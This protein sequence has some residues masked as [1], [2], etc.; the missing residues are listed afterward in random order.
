MDIHPDCKKRLVNLLAEI[1]PEIQVRNN[2]FLNYQSTSRLEE[3]DDV[4]PNRGD[5]KEELLTYIGENPLSVF[6]RE[7][8]FEK[9]KDRFDFENGKSDKLTDLDGFKNEKELSKELITEFE[10]LPWD[11]TFFIK[12]PR[13]L[14]SKLINIINEI[15]FSLNDRMSLIKPSNE[16]YPNP[17]KHGSLK[18]FPSLDF[19]DK[20]EQ[21]W[22]SEDLY[23]KYVTK[24]YVG[25][26]DQ[27][28]TILELQ[29]LVKSFLG[30][31]LA[32]R[33]VDFENS[34]TGSS[35]ETKIV[36]YH[37]VG[38]EWIS[39][40]VHSFPE[41]F[42]NEFEKLD[43]WSTWFE[44]FEER[45][46]KAVIND[47]LNEISKVFSN[48]RENHLLLRSS[49]WFFDSYCN[50]NDLLG[51]VQSITSI[52]ILLGDKASSD[53]IG[54]GELLSNRCAYLI[55]NTKSQRDEV[56]KDF[57][58]IYATR[59]KIVH[60]GKNRLNENERK[61]L[62]KLRW[63]CLRSIQEEIILVSKDSS[64]D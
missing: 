21:N 44:K 26:L 24:G 25:P 34:R 19:L 29:D 1:I 31:C 13:S 46:R 4:L 10:S 32:K 49:Q 15:P 9:L 14:G 61:D 36:T 47:D 42:S 23:I 53:I 3:L 18:K 11:Y 30:L 7:R 39:K 2:I 6:I 20:K 63:L 8:L 5:I 58:R 35:F 57:K 40:D 45:Q 28:N 17:P 37:N 60:R 55:G 62:H 50:E 27:T 33:V 43:I 48:I 41:S 64:D 51:F 52:E 16:L 22:D 59:S 54:I 12:F 56:L 38:N